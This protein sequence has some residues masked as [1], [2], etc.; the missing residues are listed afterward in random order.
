MN[1]TAQVT[2]SR[3]FNASP[4][5]VFDAWLDP[6]TVGKWLFA[7]PAGQMVRVEVDARA[8]G[9]WIIVD[10]RNGEDVAHSG[11]YI[12]IDRPRRLVFTFCVLQYSPLT[13]EVT[14]EIRPADS[15]CDLTL[16]QTNV[17][18]E[19]LGSNEKGWT[20]ILV[21]LAEYL[22]QYVANHI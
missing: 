6:Q 16:T 9:K 18:A 21:G 3:H 12:E 8:G 1:A 5:R 7:T 4:E 17:P 14:V 19:Y 2:V 20:G 15:G 10:H 22:A 13:T 11:E